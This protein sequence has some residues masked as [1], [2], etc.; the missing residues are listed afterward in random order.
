MF[1][2]THSLKLADNLVFSNS[3]LFKKSLPLRES[4]A[5]IKIY[6]MKGKRKTLVIIYYCTKGTETKNSSYI[7]TKTMKSYFGIFTI[8][9]VREA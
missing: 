4:L 9:I 2:F 6:H 5:S 3:T 1:F 8:K 7:T